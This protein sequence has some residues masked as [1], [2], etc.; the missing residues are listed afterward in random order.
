MVNG[1]ITGAPVHYRTVAATAASR[2]P[3]PAVAV[4]W[5]K[6][7]WSLGYRYHADGLQRG[8]CWSAAYSYSDA[9]QDDSREAITAIARRDS[10]SRL[11]AAYAEFG[12]MSDPLEVRA[13]IENIALKYGQQAVSATEAALKL[14]LDKPFWSEY[15]GKVTYTDALGDL[16]EVAPPI[17]LPTPPTRTT[18][19]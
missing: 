18:L 14:G 15:D 3:V 16:P 9:Q 4:G 17:R 19:P 5:P 12:K 2:I 1:M 11:N 7:V 10:Q 6:C 8:G 13:F